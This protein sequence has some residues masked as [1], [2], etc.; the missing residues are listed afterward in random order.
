VPPPTRKVRLA[1][2]STSI[3]AQCLVRT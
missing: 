1:S 3:R 2:G